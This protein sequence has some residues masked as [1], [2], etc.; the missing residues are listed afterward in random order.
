[1]MTDF[2]LEQGREMKNFIC[3]RCLGVPLEE[4]LALDELKH[5]ESG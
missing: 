2:F 5:E 1:M 3:H 4:K